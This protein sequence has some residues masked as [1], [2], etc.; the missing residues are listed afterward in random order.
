MP[1]TADALRIHQATVAGR[2]TGSEAARILQRAWRRRRAR[3]NMQLLRDRFL[4]RKRALAERRRVQRRLNDKQKVL[5]RLKGAYEAGGA[6]A[7]LALT[8]GT[9]DGAAKAVQRAWRARKRREE[10][11]GLRRAAAEEAAS[12]VIQRKFRSRDLWKATAMPRDTMAEPPAPD[13]LLRHEE[14]VRSKALRFQRADWSHLSDDELRAMATDRYT[15]FL[16]GVGDRR[17]KLYRAQVW[18]AHTHESIAAMKK[19]R[20]LHE[21]PV[22]RPSKLEDHRERGR[23][24]LI[25]TK[26][27][28]AHKDKMEEMAARLPGTGSPARSPR[29]GRSSSPR[30]V[31]DLAEQDRL[32]KSLED[33]LA[34]RSVF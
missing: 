10:E 31:D 20:S 29:R 30:G 34:H 7:L 5:E 1:L 24:M 6:K 18:A 13:V 16:Q 32:L 25:T 8:G 19:M 27:K 17:A 9:Q 2:L 11:G 26:A 28:A 3:V 22:F 14:S 21:Q 23:S 12:T 15:G 4:A 33:E